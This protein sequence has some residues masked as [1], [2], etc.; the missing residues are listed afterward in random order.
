MGRAS[1]PLKTS[2]WNHTRCANPIPDESEPRRTEILP[3]RGAK[4]V[5]L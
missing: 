3:F 5:K 2:G 1:D 4:I